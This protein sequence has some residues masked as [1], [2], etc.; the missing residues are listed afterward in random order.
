MK[1]RNV[2]QM[3]ALTA[4]CHALPGFAQPTP[5]VYRIAV[6]SQV[7]ARSERIMMYLERRLAEL[8]YQEGRNLVIDF[9]YADGKPELLPGLA[10]QLLAAKPD[11]IVA[12]LNPEVAVLKRS[13]A[14][15]P[16]VMLFASS[17]V[18]SGL[19]ASLARPGGNITG[20]MA[21]APATA[22]K[23]TQVLRD[24]VPGLSRIT[25]LCEP[26]YPG[27]AQYKRE[28]EKA[29]T[30]MGLHLTM[31]D[32]RNLSD[33]E[34]ALAATARARPEGVAVSMTGVM[35]SN[36]LR[37][38]EFM[39]RTKIPTLYTTPRPVRSGGLMSYSTDML[40]IMDRDAW[41]ID[42]ILKGTKPS[43]IPVEEP[44]KFSF[45]INLKTARAMGFT[46]PQALLVQA[47]GVFE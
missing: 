31:L 5:K 37:I 23:A 42:K 41:M 14:T 33:L 9:Q 2:L 38:I 20:T 43:E 39:S 18:D 34:A 12:P 29:C 11:L 13:T 35:L 3:T 44:T 21:M 27:M 4:L 26:D 24:A 22:G 1:R 15:I 28:I 19:I 47:D 25:W 17:P 30:A 6:L 40:A 45:Q 16:I 32:V 36:E 10:A 7:F 46:F 8:G